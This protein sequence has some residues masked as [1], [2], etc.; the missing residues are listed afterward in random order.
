MAW[1]GNTFINKRKSVFCV[2]YANVRKDSRLF[3]RK[4]EH[5]LEKHYIGQINFYRWRMN[6]A[7][8]PKLYI[9]K[10]WKFG[11]H[12]QPKQKAW[13]LD[14]SRMWKICIVFL[15]VFVL[16]LKSNIHS[17]LGCQLKIIFPIFLQIFVDGWCE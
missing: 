12:R 11:H 6:F 17:V 8:I 15:A 4:S 14:A 9:R 5:I 3:P 7:E 13:Q 1:K 16:L 10:F 2:H